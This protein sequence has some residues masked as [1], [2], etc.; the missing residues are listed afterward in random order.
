MLELDTFPPI[1]GNGRWAFRRLNPAAL[2]ARVWRWVV[3]VPLP[4]CLAGYGSVDDEWHNG[5][6]RQ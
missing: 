2:R 3:L 1:E 5:A 6:N 4:L